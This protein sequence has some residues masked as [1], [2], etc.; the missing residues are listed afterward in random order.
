MPYPL[1]IYFQVECIG[2]Q[3]LYHKCR[4]FVK[5]F[6]SDCK[7]GHVAR[8]VIILNYFKVEVNMNQF[9]LNISL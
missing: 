4:A 6:I 8:V 7:S 2:K 3:E 9:L 1:L 5:M